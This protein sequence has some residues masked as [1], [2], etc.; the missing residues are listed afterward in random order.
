[1][2]SIS[3]TVSN[4]DIRT[5][6][7]EGPLDLLCYLIEKNKVSIYDIPVIDITDQYIDF[8]S[9]MN[10]IDMELTTEFLVMAS[11]LLIIKSK[12]L[13]PGK[14][15]AE[16]ADGDDP[17]EELVIKLLE[18]RRCKSLADEL[19][20]RYTEYR[21]CVFKL[22][23]TTGSLGIEQAC[24]CE[25]FSP[26]NFFNACKVVADRNK[27]RFYDVTNRLL[28]I[29]K[30]DRVSLKDK[31]KMIWEGVVSRTRVF[32]NEL[33]PADTMTKSERVVG[34]LALLELLKSDRLKVE[35]SFPFD[36]IYIEKNPDTADE[37]DLVFEKH[38]NR[39]KIEEINYQ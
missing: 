19:R 15:S 34:F 37:G 6:A 38:F 22:P 20:I 32:F 5:G 14:Q 36:V 26:D 2:S 7:F 11:T 9:K 31:M 18:Y 24:A 25:T 4:P 17:R 1:M 13:L 21:N 23:E 28:H 16:G 3:E 30:R 10:I 29:L 33:F 39:Q 12:M 8:I 27:I 35:Q